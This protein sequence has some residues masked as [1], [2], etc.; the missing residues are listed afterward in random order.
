MTMP[1]K[2]WAQENLYRE[3]MSATKAPAM[4]QGNTAYIRADLAEELARA[5]D[6]LVDEMNYLPKYAVEA[7]H[8]Y[9]A[10]ITP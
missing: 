8:R 10:A 5:L 9:N 7:L 3:T 6:M 2:I 4:D 1:S